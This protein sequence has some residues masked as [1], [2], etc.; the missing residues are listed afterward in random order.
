MLREEAIDYLEFEKEQILNKSDGIKSNL[1]EAY[2]MAIEE[3]KK[4]KYK[5]GKWIILDSNEHANLCK[6]S[7]CN[8]IF[9]FYNGEFATKFC[10]ECGADM[11]GE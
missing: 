11:R 3:L 2:D 8:E 10:G 9:T 4:S 6:C 1:T 5:H 7:V